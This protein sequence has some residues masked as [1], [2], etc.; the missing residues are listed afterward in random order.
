MP[1]SFSVDES[2]E[3][4]SYFSHSLLDDPDGQ[5]GGILDVTVF[6][7]SVT[8]YKEWIMNNNEF[9]YKVV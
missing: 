1:S 2:D 9:Y 6:R 4:C 3:L 7:D 5:S 8:R